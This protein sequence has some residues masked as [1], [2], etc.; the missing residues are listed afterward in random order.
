MRIHHHIPTLLLGFNAF[1]AALDLPGVIDVVSL[2]DMNSW[3]AGHG[4]WEPILYILLMMGMFSRFMNGS[5]SK[6]PKGT[7]LLSTMQTLWITPLDSHQC[8]HLHTLHSFLSG[9][10]GIPL[11][12]E[13]ISSFI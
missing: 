8:N 3:I 4:S 11:V 7:F 6:L 10:H 2:M 1:F 13:I 9:S 5:S 12:L